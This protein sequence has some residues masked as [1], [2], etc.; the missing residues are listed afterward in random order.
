MFKVAGVSR[1][2]GQVKVRFANDMTRVKLLVKAGN[3]DIELIE[4]E[5]ALDKAGCV[6]ALKAS[7]L[8]QNVAYVEAIDEA[9]EKYCVVHPADA[10]KEPKVP[11][12]PKTTD[13]KNA[14]PSIEAIKARIKDAALDAGAIAMKPAVTDEATDVA[15]TATDTDVD[16]TEE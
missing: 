10:H 4:L 3:S 7:V 6:E 1:F 2:K 15:D 12:A 13:K 16:T 14:A 9:Y 11:K 8:Y 5:T